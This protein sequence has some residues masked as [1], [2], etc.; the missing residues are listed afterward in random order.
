MMIIL[1]KIKGSDGD[2]FLQS[3]FRTRLTFVSLLRGIRIFELIP[4]NVQIKILFESFAAFES[5]LFR[6]FYPEF[7]F[8]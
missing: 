6:N 8:R 5:C 4:K 2:I 3:S 1:T 7:G